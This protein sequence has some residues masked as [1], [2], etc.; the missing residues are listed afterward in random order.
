MKEKFMPL[1][2]MGKILK[3]NGAKRA[4]LGAKKALKDELEIIAKEIAKKAVR[5]SEHAK[6][7]TVQAEDIKFALKERLY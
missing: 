2:A 7:R 5:Y 6:R 4:S 1:F 3:K